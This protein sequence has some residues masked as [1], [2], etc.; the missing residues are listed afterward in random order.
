MPRHGGE[1]RAIQVAF[2]M[3]ERPGRH[4]EAS[5]LG[6]TSALLTFLCS[7]VW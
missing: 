3:P 6:H 1:P 7:G 2:A 5:W 4:I